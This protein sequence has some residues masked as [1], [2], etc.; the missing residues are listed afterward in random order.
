MQ[1]RIVVGYSSNLKRQREE[2]NG[3]VISRLIP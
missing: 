2:T 3:D 1:M